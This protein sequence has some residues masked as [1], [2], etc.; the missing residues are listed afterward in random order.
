MITRISG[1]DWTADLSH[2]DVEIRIYSTA[3]ATCPR[4]LS[5][6]ELIAA[7]AELVRLTGNVTAVEEAFAIVYPDRD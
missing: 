6:L 7:K 4:E 3:V 1:R 2:K 5:E